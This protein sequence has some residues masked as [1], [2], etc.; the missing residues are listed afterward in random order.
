MSSTSRLIV[1][2]CWISHS[3][4]CCNADGQMEG[5]EVGEDKIEKECEVGV[6]GVPP[7]VFV[8]VRAV[9]TRR[10]MI[11]VIVLD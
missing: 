7:F 1:G 6:D 11:S 9:A 5:D 2:G 8:A 3:T 4:I 10:G